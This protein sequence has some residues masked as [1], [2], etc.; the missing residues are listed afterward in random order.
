VKLFILDADSMNGIDSSGVHAIE[1]IID[2]CKDKNIEFQFA[3]MKGPIRDI[4]HRAKVVEKIGEEH[5]FFRIQHAIDY[6][7]KKSKHRY[8][9]YAL[10]TNEDE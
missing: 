5:F 1:E 4:L 10:Q 9:E 2:Y 8:S 7:D 3:G 6:F